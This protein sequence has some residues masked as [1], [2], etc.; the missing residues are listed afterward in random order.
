MTRTSDDS[1]DLKTGVGVTATM[2]AAARAVAGRGPDPLIDDPFAEVLVRAVGLQLFTRIVDGRT[3]FS[4][5]GAGWAP[6]FFGIRTR[7]IDDSVADACRAGIRQ[8]VILAAGLDSRAYRL[9]WP[10]AMSLYEVDQPEVIDWK[11]NFMSKLECTS[12]A[13]HRCLGIDLRRDWPRALQE[14]GFDDSQPTVWIVEGLLV[15]YLPSSAHDE[16]LD[17]ITALSA[18]GSRI[19]ADYFDSRGPDVLTDTLNDLHDIWGELDPCLNLQSLT[20]SGPHQDPAVYLGERGWTTFNDE[21]AALFVAAGRSAP[22]PTDFPEV[23][24]FFRMLRG[25]R[26]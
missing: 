1:W 25:V 24:K 13:Q 15:G 7:S 21:F 10:P 9:D 26:S 2:V 18:S 22:G 19:A 20:Y 11:Q 4:D 3:G 8:A 6:G 17:A 23:A 16:I 12:T 5:V 14:A